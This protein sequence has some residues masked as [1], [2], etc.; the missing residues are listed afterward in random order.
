MWSGAVV[1]AFVVAAVIG[2][3]P[4]LVLMRHVDRRILI[5]CRVVG[6]I[7]E[8]WAELVARQRFVAEELEMGLGI[9]TRVF[10][11]VMGLGS[12]LGLV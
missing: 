8:A 10:G 5:G 11:I 7:L 1:G 6:Q 9:G 3:I 2:L 12:E 4:Y